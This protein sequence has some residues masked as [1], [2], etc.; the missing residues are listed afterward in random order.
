MKYCTLWKN[1]IGFSTINIYSGNKNSSG[2]NGSERRKRNVGQLAKNGTHERLPREYVDQRAK[3]L[4]KIRKQ[5]KHRHATSNVRSIEYVANES[6][7]QSSS[8]EEMHDPAKSYCPHFDECSGCSLSVNFDRS[9][10][11]ERARSFFEKLGKRYDFPIHMG[12]LIHWRYKARL[13]VRRCSRSGDVLVGL[14]RHGSHDCIDIPQCVA[15]HPA[16]NAV[17]DLIRDEIVK[18]NVEP[19]DETKGTGNLRYVQLQIVDAENPDYKEEFL[20]NASAQSR[21]KSMVQIVLVWNAQHFD[22]KDTVLKL[23]SRTIWESRFIDRRGLNSSFEVHSVHVNFQPMRSNTIMG[24]RTVLLY[25]SEESLTRFGKLSIYFGPQAF[26]QV[27][28]GAMNMALERMRPWVPVGSRVADLHAGVGTISLAMASSQKLQLLRLIEI[29]SAG[30]KYFWK[31]WRTLMNVLAKNQKQNP[32]EIDNT[33]VGDRVEYIVAAAGEDPARWLKCIDVAIC[34]PPRKGLENS[35]LDFLC[36]NDGKNRL[37]N[38]SSQRRGL[39]KRLIY[40]SCGWPA[41]ERDCKALLRS[42]VWELRMAE[43]FLF[44]P[45]ADHIETLAIFDLKLFEND[46]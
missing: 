10:T 33:I 23:F 12:N 26:M 17:G 31:S 15:H 18:C 8:A 14:F 43:G 7:H 25:G 32:L 36:G 42:G 40:L 37:A 45:G 20:D 34:D 27:N 38:W 41:F 1:A 13:A 2:G 39:P 11:I 44:F 22:K 29:S 9:P 4:K 24:E 3:S 30:K 19:Y 5:K 21:S 16:L 6:L 28:P 46:V 35:L